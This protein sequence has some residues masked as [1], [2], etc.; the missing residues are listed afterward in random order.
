MSHICIIDLTSSTDRNLLNANLIIATIDDLTG[1]IINPP[2]PIANGSL[3]I[4]SL[5]TLNRQIIEKFQ[6]ATSRDRYFGGI[7]IPDTMIVNV[8]DRVNELRTDIQNLQHQLDRTL[9][10]DSWSIIREQL[11]H[12]MLDLAP[13][14]SI[15]SLPTIEIFRLYRSRIHHLLPTYSAKE[16]EL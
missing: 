4:K 5:V 2:H 15:R 14:E 1:A 6:R 8:A 10:Q 9:R 12:S 11:L 13:T 7:Q 3:N 16:I